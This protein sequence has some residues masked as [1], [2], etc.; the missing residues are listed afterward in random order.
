MT[1]KTDVRNIALIAGSG[2]LGVLGTIAF[3]GALQRPADRAQ[4]V[5]V[6]LE[7]V[8]ISA[9]EDGR[10]MVRATDGHIRIVGPGLVQSAGQ[11][12]PIIYV[13]GVRLDRSDDAL[14]RLNP[15]RIDRVEVL[16][17]TAA[18][19]LYGSEGEHGV[20]QIYLKSPDEAS[21]NADRNGR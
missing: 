17:G 19:H 6:E 14:G 5:A 11:G 8:R 15:D 4:K 7:H 10:T 21:E 12:Q 13:D 20:I 9:G 3:L 2:V 16:K 1:K 18:K